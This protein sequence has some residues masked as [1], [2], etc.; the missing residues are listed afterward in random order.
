MRSGSVFSCLVVVVVVGVGASWAGCTPPETPE[1]E[2]EGEANEGE[3]EGDGGTEGE[4]EVAVDCG[5]GCGDG[6][7]CGSI[8]TGADDVAC[9]ATCDDGAVPCETAS[10]LSGDCRV[11]AAFA[12]PVCRAQAQNLEQCGNVVNAGCFD[13]D[14]VC[15]GFGDEALFPNDAA[16]CDDDAGCGDAALGCSQDFVFLAP[17]DPA[18]HG[19]CAPLTTA[20]SPCGRRGDGTLSFCTTGLS[21]D[22]L[23]GETVGACVAE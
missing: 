11:I 14:A 15:V 23:D 8:F 21:C 9:Y 4:G 19:V 1:G 13:D 10:G 3:G 17:G 7:L 16:T 20:G 5:A 12:E 22:R 2:G 18:P 6:E